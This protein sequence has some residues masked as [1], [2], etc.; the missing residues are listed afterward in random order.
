MKRKLSKN[1]EKECLLCGEKFSTHTGKKLYCGL[2]EKGNRT[3]CSYLNHLRSSRD[4]M[5]R[6]RE[7]KKYD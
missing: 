3:K 2:S 4:A 7:A 5:K 1:I 6:R